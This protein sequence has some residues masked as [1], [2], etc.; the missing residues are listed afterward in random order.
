MANALTRNNDVVPRPI[1]TEMV[2]SIAIIDV[3]TLVIGHCH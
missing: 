3:T 1:M 2:K